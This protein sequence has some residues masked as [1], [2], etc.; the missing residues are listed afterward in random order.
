V[1]ICILSTPEAL[2]T[3]IFKREPDSIAISINY[4]IYTVPQTRVDFWVGAGG[5]IEL[6]PHEFKDMR[7]VLARGSLANIMWAC[8]ACSISPLFSTYKLEHFSFVDRPFANDTPTIV[9][10]HSTLVN[11]TFSWESSHYHVSCT[12]IAFFIL[13]FCILSLNGSVYK[14]RFNNSILD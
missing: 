4:T 13:H 14:G 9:R 2:H 5:L 6:I 8:E 10:N 1:H 3:R 11:F 7:S 12:S